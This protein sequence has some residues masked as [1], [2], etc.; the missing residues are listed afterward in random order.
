MAKKVDPA[1][2]IIDT[3]L[4]LA[5]EKR[6][7]DISLAEIAVASKQPLSKVYP[8]F[9]SKRAI[10]GAFMRR[11]DAAV[12]AAQDKEALEGSARD[13]LFDVLM[14]RFDALAPYKEAVGHI[15]YDLGRDPLMSVCAIPQ[16]A[17]SMS[18]M[19]EAA[20]L[21]AGGL[22]GAVRV[23]VLGVLY[24]ATVRVWLRDNTEDLSHTMAALDR[25]LRRVEW[26]AQRF[27]QAR[28]RGAR[29]AAPAA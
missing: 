11:I 24:L 6:W 4:K 21:S 8:L 26:L 3:A 29:P 18:C 25:H 19:L 22:R 15:L 10:L 17:R 14:H 12:L 27:S 20:D 1:D 28:D 23:D 9:S 16:F 13:R 5:T 2:R 7:R